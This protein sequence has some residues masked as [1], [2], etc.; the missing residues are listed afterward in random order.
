MSKKLNKETYIAFNISLSE[1]V[2]MKNSCECPNI[3]IVP[4]PVISLNTLTIANVP[5]IRPKP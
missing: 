4:G 1:P 3:P 2:A 5:L